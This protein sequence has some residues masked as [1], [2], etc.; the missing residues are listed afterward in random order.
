VSWKAS[1]EKN[2]LIHRQ[3]PLL[4]IHSMMLFMAPFHCN[5]QSPDG[6]QLP[7]VR[8]LRFSNRLSPPTM[9]FLEAL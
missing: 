9:Q 7:K 4:D 8:H 5:V 3:S 6:K 1:T 2:S